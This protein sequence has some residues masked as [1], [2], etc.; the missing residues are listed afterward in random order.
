MTAP[1]DA[2]LTAEE[3]KE[4][5]EL[6]P[7][8]DALKEERLAAAAARLA[9]EA[10]LGELK[11]T[12]ESNLERRQ[13]QIETTT[14]EVDMAGVRRISHAPRRTPPLPPPKRQRRAR[15]TPK[16][17]RR[18]PPH[19]PRCRSARRRSNAFATR[20]TTPRLVWLTTSARWRG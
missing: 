19:P 16:S 3:V 13:L 10:E 2:K 6:N 20:R 14:S 11:A 5:A 8:L 9:A 4:L 7:R 1:L 12:L 15:A 17:P 18:F